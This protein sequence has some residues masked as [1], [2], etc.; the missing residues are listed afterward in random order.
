[1][2]FVRKRTLS[3]INYCYV[4]KIMSLC[5]SFGTTH[6]KLTVSRFTLILQLI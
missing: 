3:V 1:M 2:N 4:R 5:F 6:D